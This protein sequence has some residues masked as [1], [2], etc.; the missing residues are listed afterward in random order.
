MD[1]FFFFTRRGEGQGC[2]RR[3]GESR[4]WVSAGEVGEE[5]EEVEV[6]GDSFVHRERREEGEHRERRVRDVCC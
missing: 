2:V 6:G 4:A 5:E 1:R 3:S